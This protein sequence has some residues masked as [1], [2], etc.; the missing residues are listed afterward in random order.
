MIEWWYSNSRGVDIGHVEAF[1]DRNEQFLKQIHPDWTNHTIR[2]RFPAWALVKTIAPVEMQNC[3]A[4]QMTDMIAWGRNRLESGSHWETDPHYTTA[5]QAANTIR[6]IHRL[7]NEQ[8]LFEF[9]YRE[10]GD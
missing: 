9:V 3:P 4:I 2:E 5:E 6:W 10:E 7:W 8:A 1:F